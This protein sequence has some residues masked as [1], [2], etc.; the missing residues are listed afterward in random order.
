MNLNRTNMTAVEPTTR[1]QP[2]Y[3]IAR[4]SIIPRLPDTS[5]KQ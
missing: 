4:E 3:F 1:E 5:L 2:S